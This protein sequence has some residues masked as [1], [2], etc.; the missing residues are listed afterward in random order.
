MNV[1]IVNKNMIVL[2]AILGVVFFLSQILSTSVLG[3][4]SHE[5]DRIRIQKEQYRLENEML[6][7]EINKEKSV[8]GSI[9]VSEKYQLTE[10]NVNYLIDSSDQV[11]LYE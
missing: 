10:K 3:A 11:A 9:S 8:A 7:S 2:N 4:K 5:I 1:R 6:I